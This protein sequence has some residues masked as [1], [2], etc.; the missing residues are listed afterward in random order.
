MTAQLSN[1]ACHPILGE[2][3]DDDGSW[4]TGWKTYSELAETVRTTVADLMRRLSILGV[5]EK[6]DGRHRLTRN[7]RMKG[8]GTVHRVEV[9]GGRRIRMDVILPD[10]MVFLV[11]NL[12]ATNA[13]LSEAEGLAQEGLSLSAVAARLGISKQAVHKRLNAVPPQLKD[14]PVVGAWADDGEADN[15]N[16]VNPS[17]SAA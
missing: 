8:H 9:E 2:I 17:V 12:Q 7:A 11:Q 6:R 5:V 4:V 15:D 16:S 3:R 10:G 13:P 1:R 14:W